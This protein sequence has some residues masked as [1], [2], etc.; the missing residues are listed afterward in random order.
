[1]L[2][3]TLSFHKMVMSQDKFSLGVDAD[4]CLTV[5]PNLHNYFV[6]YSLISA[7]TFCDDTLFL[8]ISPNFNKSY[9]QRSGGR[10]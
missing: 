3:F 7:V 2:G 8:L 4:S 6:P 9:K 10:D 5:Q 1:M